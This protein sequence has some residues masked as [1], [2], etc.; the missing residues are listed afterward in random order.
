M[1]LRRI[2]NTATIIVFPIVDADGDLVSGAAG[3]D[4]ELDS[5]ADGSA[6]DGFVDCTNEATEIGSTGNY[7]LSLTAGEMNA[8]YI[9][10]QVKTSTSGAKTQVLLINTKFAPLT[11]D[12]TAIKAKTDNLPATPANE[13]T[14]TTIAS[15][16]DTE[17]A[18]IKAKT[19]NLPASPAA[20]SDIPTSNITAIKA[21]TDSL[22]FSVAGQ[23]DANVQ[24]VNNVQITGN[25]E[26][27]TE[28]GPV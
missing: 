26:V 18:A 17:V 10:V 19:D 1:E 3:L 6:P 11:S 8:D 13:A 20:T 9:V 24:Y 7:Y 21:K 16:I 23:V 5:W 14:L 12:V 25:G 27:G 15:Y 28:W 4:S 2:K 22:T